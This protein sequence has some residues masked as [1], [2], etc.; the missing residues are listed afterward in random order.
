MVSVQFGRLIDDD[1]V[2]PHSTQDRTFPFLSLLDQK[3]GEVP[4]DVAAEEAALLR[5]EVLVEGR[6]V[7]A[8]GDAGRGMQVEAKRFFFK[9]Y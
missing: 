6:L 2:T 3:F 7:L 9:F 4:L 1:R 5:L 8:C